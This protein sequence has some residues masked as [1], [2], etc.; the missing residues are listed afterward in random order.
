MGSFSTSESHSS[1]WHQPVRVPIR[2]QDVFGVAREMCDDLESWKILGV[3]EEAL[4]ITCE[5]TGGFLAGTAK[6]VVSVTGPDGI[7][8]SETNVHSETGG[9]LLSK[10]KAIVTEFVKKFSMRVI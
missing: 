10:D 2:K 9:G 8:S 7:P 5:R 6:I 1:R 4:T 3:D